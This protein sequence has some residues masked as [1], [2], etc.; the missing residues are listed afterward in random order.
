MDV[1]PANLHEVESVKRFIAA[2]DAYC[3]LLEN[4]TAFTPFEFLK[5]VASAIA[6]LYVAG[7]ALPAVEC[8]DSQVNESTKSSERKSLSNEALK[9][10]G[11]KLGDF[12]LYWK[13]FNPFEDEVPV[14]AGILDDLN[15][16][17]LDYRR[18]LESFRSRT[19]SGMCEAVWHWRFMFEIHW[20]NHA[21]DSL[22]AIHRLLTMEE[23]GFRPSD[24][25]DIDEEETRAE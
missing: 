15:D 22:R 2:G 11:Q 14:Q 18:Y 21:V 24:D 1:E 10:I 20:G 16:V 4:S 7:L 13:V 12:E 23:Y 9:A 8:V 5:Q 3:T 6:T 19:P 17:Y 25:D